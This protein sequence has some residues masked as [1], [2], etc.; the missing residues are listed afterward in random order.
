MYLFT[1]LVRE[2]VCVRMLDPLGL[3]FQEVVNRLS[4]CLK[5]NLDPPEEYAQ[6]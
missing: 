2:R 3:D 6:F 4:G 1:Y 5:R